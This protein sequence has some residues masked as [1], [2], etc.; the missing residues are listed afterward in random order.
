[1]VFCQLLFLALVV[2][3]APPLWAEESRKVRD[4]SGNIVLI[5]VKVERVAPLIGAFVQITQMLTLGQSKVV[6]YPTGSISDYFLEVFPDL[7]LKN[8][9]RYDTSSVEEIITS[10]AQVVF[11]P[12]GR[13]SDVEKRQLNAASIAVVPINGL[14]TVRE[15][16]ESFLLIG[17]ILGPEEKERA[18]AFVEYYQDSLAWPYA[19]IKEIKESQRPR[20]LVLNFIGGAL[21]TINK[22][23]ICH[24]YITSAG[25]INLAA[26][27][28]AGSGG[29]TQHIDPESVILWDPEI[30][31][32]Y[33]QESQREIL[34]N[35]AL[36]NVRAVKNKRI[37]TVPY[38]IYLWSVRSG[39]GALM[40]PWLGTVFYPQLFSDVDLEELVRDFYLRFYKHS[41]SDEEVVSILAGS[42]N[43][44]TRGSSQ[45][46]GAR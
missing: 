4:S 37:Y 26:D 6:A 5:P 44:N 41:P 22:F 2:P 15:L 21:G 39:E 14:A 17:E 29:I 46:K 34:S 36:Q 32:T 3:Q 28:L 7:I 16:K 31:L 9:H 33:S 40:T 42:K 35:S 12:D 20:V 13:L 43:L 10:R 27:Y 24:E 19:R 11:G 45:G 1:M 38:G 8:P 23:D 25:G 30:I 18:Q